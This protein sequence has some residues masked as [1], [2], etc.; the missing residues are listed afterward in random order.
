MHSAVIYRKHACRHMLQLAGNRL[1]FRTYTD[2][3][4]RQS[5]LICAPDFFVTWYTS[6]DV[7]DIVCHS[8]CQTILTFALRCFTDSQ[9]DNLRG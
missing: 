8:A 7:N 3:M 4:H 9:L 6:R 1:G 5:V 2:H